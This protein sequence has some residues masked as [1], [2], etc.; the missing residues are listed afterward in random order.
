MRQLI[1]RK[2]K[3]GDF[4]PGE[5]DRLLAEGEADIARGNIVIGEQAFR[6]LDEI[7]AARGMGKREI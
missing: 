6:E 2:Q 4:T 3:H 5:L 1:G 7:S